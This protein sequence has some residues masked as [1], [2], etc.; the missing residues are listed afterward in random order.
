MKKGFTLV[1]VFLTLG[2]IGIIAAMTI[3]SMIH[4]STKKATIEQLQK[5]AATLN[6]AVYNATITNG[7]VST[8][9]WQADDGILDIMQNIISPR[10]NIGYMCSG[11]VN[12]ISRQC[13][14]TVDGLDGKE[15]EILNGFDSKTRVVLN[16]GSLIAF[17]GGF[18]EENQGGGAGGSGSGGGSADGDKDKPV[19]P[20]SWG[21]DDQAI[22]GIFLIDVNGSEKPNIVGRDVFFYAL[23]LN[24]AVLPFGANQTEDFIDENCSKEGDG[25]SGKTCAAKLVNGGWDVCY[26]CDKP[27]PAIF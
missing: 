14:Y 21:A 22:C 25:V 1:E 12:N 6:T 9:R 10:L 4:V 20:C 16:D 18:P 5:S 8:W 15:A 13:R 26:T 3:P 17:A 7:E 23:H 11:D 19:N 27:Y 24:G 2:I